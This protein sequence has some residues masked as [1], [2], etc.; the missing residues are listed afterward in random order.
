MASEY[1]ACNGM[2]QFVVSWLNFCSHFA[3]IQISCTS[4]F[5]P[6]FF[7]FTMMT[8]SLL[9][10]MTA[11][12]PTVR[13]EP[14]CIT[15]DIDSLL[16]SSRRLYE[17]C[18]FFDVYLSPLSSIATDYRLE[19]Y[20]LECQGPTLPVA[21]ECEKRNKSISVPYTFFRHHCSKFILLSFNLFKFIR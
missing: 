8:T 16:K 17:N 21:G 13:M 1:L 4:I 20:V 15:C 18:S 9:L 10:P 14:Q 19:H 5:R 2:I 7:I 12:T 3:F 11:T 6:V